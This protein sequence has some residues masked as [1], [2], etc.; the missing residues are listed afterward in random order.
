[1]M[2]LAQTH[3][4]DWRDYLRG[5]VDEMQRR[6]AALPTHQNIAQWTRSDFFRDVA[7]CHHALG[8]VWRCVLEI[9]TSPYVPPN[10][11]IDVE[12]VI[13]QCIGVHLFID[14]VSTELLPLAGEKLPSS[15]AEL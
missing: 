1:M 14:R 5:L 10:L 3:D 2:D 7:E 12:S 11:R 6:K 9:N 15:W 4:L 13:Y 8:D